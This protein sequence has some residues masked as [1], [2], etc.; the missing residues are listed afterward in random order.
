MARQGRVF[1]SRRADYFPF[2]RLVE[3]DEP[4]RA[5]VAN[6]AARAAAR[7]RGVFVTIN[8]KAE[9]SAPLSVL[10]LAEVITAAIQLMA[11][12]HATA[13]TEHI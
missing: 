8:N 6:L 5:A 1:A 10:R 4:T 7:G 11:A 3:E 13:H 9:G 2:D 12:A